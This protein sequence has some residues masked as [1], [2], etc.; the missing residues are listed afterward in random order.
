M[1][2]TLPCGSTEGALKVG[3]FAGLLTY[4]YAKP[5]KYDGRLVSKDNHD[6]RASVKQCLDG[7]WAL[8]C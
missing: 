2:S 3:C 4:Q 8:C 1:Q 7:F 5:T 6:S